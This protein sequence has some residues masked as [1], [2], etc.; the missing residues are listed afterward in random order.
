MPCVFLSRPSSVLPCSSRHAY[1][2]QAFPLCMWHRSVNCAVGAILLFK[3]KSLFSSCIHCTCMCKV[4]LRASCKFSLRASSHTYTHTHIHTRTHAHEH[5]HV[6]T[7]CGSGHGWSAEAL[8]PPKEPYLF[9]KEPL[10]RTL[11]KYIYIIYIYI[12]IYVYV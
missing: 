11:N 8:K 1:P 3:S 4:S 12:N 5:E 6:H 2:A 9:Q 10:K 7:V